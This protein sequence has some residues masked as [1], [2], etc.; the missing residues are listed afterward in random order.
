MAV[1]VRYGL[2]EMP[3]PAEVIRI[4]EPWR[5]YRSLAAMFLWESLKLT[6]V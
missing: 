4:G 1:M 2:G 6:P 5:P 3:P